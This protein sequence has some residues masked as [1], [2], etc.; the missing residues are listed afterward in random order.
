MHLAEGVGIEGRR[1]AARARGDQVKP[2]NGECLVV[3]GREVVGRFMSEV[4]G[5]YSC[6][7]AAE[8]LIEG[9]ATNEQV[10][11]TNMEAMA[12]GVV[13]KLTRIKELEEGRIV[14]N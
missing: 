12:P 7:E 3:S 13:G 8:R 4:V 5:P 9:V 2:R 6:A 10:G 11:H 1:N 14:H